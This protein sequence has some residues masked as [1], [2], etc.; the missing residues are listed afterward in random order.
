MS[1]EP[2][3]RISAQAR[4]PRN[5][6]I[7]WDR[8]LVLKRN[9]CQAID[10]RHSTPKNHELLRELRKILLCKI[11]TRSEYIVYLCHQ[12]KGY[13]SGQLEK[14]SPQ[15][16]IVKPKGSSRLQILQNRIARS[17]LWASYR[18][19]HSAII[20]GMNEKSTSIS[21]WFEYCCSSIITYDVIA[22]KFRQGL[23]TILATLYSYWVNAAKA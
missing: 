4:I 1:S 10:E 5:I 15:L 9:L 21:V 19:R 6:R 3:A 22:S 23:P 18:S 13:I 20:A 11:R 16:R 8:D 12:K 17:M 7:C 14:I 2:S